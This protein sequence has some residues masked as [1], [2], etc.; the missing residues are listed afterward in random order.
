M[1]YTIKLLFK[2]DQKGVI[3]RWDLRS[4]ENDMLI[5]ENDVMILSI[6]ISPDCKQ[7]V[8]V[9]NKGTAYIWSLS[10][11]TDFTLYNFFFKIMKTM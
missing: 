1:Y 5:P 3:Y 9:N 8:S 4:K 7:M 11:G 6:D 2:G 10:P